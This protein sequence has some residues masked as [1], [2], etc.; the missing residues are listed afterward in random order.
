MNGLTQPG[1]KQEAI[2]PSLAR[3]AR[4]I[5]ARLS[6]TA[7]RMLRRALSRI[8]LTTI[9]GVS[10]AVAM[11]AHSIRRSSWR[12][13]GR[14]IVTGTFH[15]PNWYLSH[16]TPISLCGVKEVILVVDEPQLP[17]DGVRFV[18]PP[19]WAA[20]LLGRAVA[21]ALWLFGAGVRYRPDLYMG[22]HVLPGACSALIV[23]SLLGRATCYQMTGGPGEVIGGGRL[24]G[25]WLTEASPKHSA[26]IERLAL[27]AVR[28]FDLVVVRGR[29]AKRFLVG[30][31]VN[32]RVAIITGSVKPVHTQ[33]K[34]PRDIDLIFVGRV[35]EV[36][37]P[38]QFVEVVAAVQRL[39]PD[40]RSA[41]LGEGPLLDDVR[42]KAKE[43]GVS[44]NIEFLG[45]R[46]D[47]EAFLARSKVFLLTSR[48][49][50]LSIAM[51]EAM[52]GGAVPVVANVG[53]LDDLVEHGANGY[54]VT[55]NR[56]EEY[57]RR[58]LSLL[59]DDRLRRRCAERAIRAA[60]SHCSLDIVTAKWGRRLTQT[61]SQCCRNGRVN[62][63]SGQAAAA[64]QEDALFREP[65][66]MQTEFE[67]Q[68]ESSE[69]PA[70]AAGETLSGTSRL[71]H[72]FETQDYCK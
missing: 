65:N 13:E 41:L 4:T 26:C 36:K 6:A 59:Q 64:S 15:N 5:C 3:K 20:R 45:K 11:L 47:V 37:Q 27:A 68:R 8:L 2:A 67:D 14:I 16:I 72:I 54:L 55:P 60:R 33:V 34:P 69:G 51:L 10:W 53:E 12:P 31:G 70:R 40:L 35:A 42:A 44:R 1:L 9:Y 19:R 23:G 46:K 43:L 21:K 39:I 61:I 25:S 58:I 32:G 7:L 56:L 38:C 71:N 62:A 49:E 48:S 22:Y 24:K 63:V 18:C 30:H 66:P 50:G 29:K 57:A 28:E 52:A 17:L